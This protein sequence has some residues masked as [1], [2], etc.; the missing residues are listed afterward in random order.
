MI[1][2]LGGLLVA[3]CAIIFAVQ[4]GDFVSVSFLQWDLNEPLAVF[5][6]AA[7][8][9]GVAAMFMFSLVILIK[10]ARTISQLQKEV[11]DLTAKVGEAS[12]ISYNAPGLG[13][14][15]DPTI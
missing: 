4:N 7:F 3:A 10:N 2:F 8:V 14:E 13:V 9:A 1:L 11:K 6:L 15:S 5:L 12:F